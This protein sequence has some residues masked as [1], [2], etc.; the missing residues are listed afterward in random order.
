MVTSTWK[1]FISLLIFMINEDPAGL[2]STVLN[3]SVGVVYTLLQLSL[4]SSFSSLIY[5]YTTA[6]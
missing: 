1:I 4:I 3:R 2:D 6:T 5:T